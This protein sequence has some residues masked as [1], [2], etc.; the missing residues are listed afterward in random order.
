MFKDKWVEK[1]DKARAY[2]VLSLNHL[3]DK[4]ADPVDK[5]KLKELISVYLDAHD[6]TT[7]VGLEIAKYEDKY[8][9][10]KEKE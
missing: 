4:V 7:R 9:V 8:S 1:R 6:F 3:T 5:A 2:K 10:K